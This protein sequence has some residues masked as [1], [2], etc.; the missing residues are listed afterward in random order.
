MP[1]KLNFKSTYIRKP[2]RVIAEENGH[3]IVEEKERVFGRWETQRIG[4]TRAEIAKLARDYPVA[5]PPVAV[6]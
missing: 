1:Q 6:V 4:M 2:L 3:V 5:A